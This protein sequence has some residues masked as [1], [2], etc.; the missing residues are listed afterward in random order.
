MIQEKSLQETKFRNHKLGTNDLIIKLSDCGYQKESILVKNCASYL[1]FSNQEHIETKETRKRLK[2]TNFCK[3]RFCEMC[4]WR[5]TKKV[6]NELIE[7]LE[8]I[9]ATRSVSYLSLTLTI[10]NPATS[11]LKATI[12]HMNES[13][14]R[15]SKTKPYKNAI[16]GHFK[17]LELLGDETKD[18][19]VHPHFHCLLIVSSSYFTGDYYLSQAKWRNM[20]AKA[21]RVDYEDDLQITIKRIKPNVRKKLSAVQSAVFEVAKYAVKHTEL[22]QRTDED[23][24]LMINQTFKMRFRSTGG[25]LKEKINLLK[26]DEDLIGVKEQTEA[27]WIEIEELIYKWQDGDYKL[28]EG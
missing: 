3:F 16:I 28:I 8:D 24:S 7:A 11:D 13:F 27:L 21:L 20:W 9:K 2:D 14:K 15:M 22:V 17:A 23:F 26:L 12:K 5:R 25:Y 6:C 1:K 19:E 4:N 10:R 18:G